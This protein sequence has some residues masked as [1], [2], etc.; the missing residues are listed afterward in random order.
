MNKLDKFY[1][2]LGLMLFALLFG[3]GN[4]IFP[5]SMGQNAGTNY[6]WAFLGFCVTGVGLPL[7]AIAAMGYSGSKD[8]LEASGRV[9]PVYGLIYT[10]LV[11]M[12]I[13]PGFALPRTGT[14]AYEIGIVPFLGGLSGDVVMP[15][16]LVVFFAAAY[17]FSATPSKLVHRVGKILSPALVIV[18]ACL[19]VQSYVNPMGSPLVPTDAYASSLTATCQG[20]LDGY[21]TMDV[22]ACLVFAGLVIEFVKSAGIT[23]FS[24][25]AGQV[26]KAGVVAAVLLAVIYFFIAKI[27]ADSVNVIG[28]K[29]TGAPVLAESA[30]FLFG[31]LG[32][33]VLAVIVIL[34]CLTTAIGL[35]SC[36]ASFFEKLFGKL[37][38]K[39]YC[40]VFAVI[41]FLIALFGL[42]TIIA[43]SIPML[44]FLY[45]LAVA[46][47]LLLFTDKLFGSRQ[48][49]YVWTIA[50]TL[51]PS[52]ESGLVTASIN[53]GGLNALFAEHV[54]L[55]SLGLGWVCF[56]VVGYVIGLLWAKFAPA[57]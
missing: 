57:K 15:A 52:A 53:L 33:A 36:C 46:L 41:S 32:A 11:Y 50:L 5:A 27:G 25:M 12:T 4:L 39:A 10:F 2:P 38:Y 14:V 31:S 24:K 35:I 34:A 18:I 28:L 48:C 42:K 3:A 29:D 40:M 19:V 51:I 44:M 56:A 8:L 20:L 26:T 54:P 16:F 7:L 17:W 9:H 6:I 22:I 30:K 47:I 55:Y 49:V 21:N 37:S 1:L 23:E 45:P 43:A 13:G